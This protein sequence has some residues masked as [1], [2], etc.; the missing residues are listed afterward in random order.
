MTKK[1]EDFLVNVD[2]AK[3][4]H[5]NKVLR[6]AEYR[7]GSSEYGQLF[8]DLMMILRAKR[9]EDK[10]S[11]EI[12]LNRNEFKDFDKFI[13]LSRDVKKM[14]K[15]GMSFDVE[16]IDKDN[17]KF[18]NLGNKE[19]RPWENKNIK[20]N[21]NY[22]T[23]IKKIQSVL[24]PDLLK[25]MWNKEFDNPLAGHCYAATEALYWILG[26]PQSDYKTYVLS[27]LTWPEGLDEGETHW[28]L[29]N[30]KGEIL[31]PTAG[32]FEDV[33]IDYNKGKYNS[34]MNYPKGGSKRAKEIIRRINLLGN[35]RQ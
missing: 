10:S 26:G 18:S 12:I 27:H 3:P 8:T 31:D 11:D 32:Q 19:S 20:E 22:N 33:E 7:K 6:F 29:R 25:G 4:I 23:T 5:G 35:E 15:L 24:T 21:V 2:E 14:R 28:F 17:I 16:V 34:M 9:E 30:S 1:Y 13:R